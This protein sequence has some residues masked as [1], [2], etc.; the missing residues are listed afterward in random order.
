MMLLF[1][2]VLLLQC[3]KIDE[4]YSHYTIKPVVIDTNTRTILLEDYTGHTCVNCAPA[5]KTANTLQEA[6]K[7]QVFV[8]G[9]HAGSFAKPDLTHYVP[10]LTADYT[11]A[12]GNEWYSYSGFNIDQNPKGMV[13]RRPYKTKISFLPSDWNNAIDSVL[14]LP[15]AAI[16][17]LNNTY[18]SANRTV[19]IQVDTKFLL[20]F[21][22]PVNLC[23]C[24]LEDSIHGGQLNSIKPDSTPIIKNFT[25]M[26]ILRGSVNGSFG[27]EIAA[28]PAANAI[29]S[30][31]YSFDFTPKSWVP[32]HCSVIA[33]IMDAGT[34]EVLHVTK[35]PVIRP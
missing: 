21:T 25:F 7:G 24:I 4:P 28:S 30:K 12:A 6:Y 1:I 15:K 29:Y 22:S 18:N 31:T 27:E 17:V 23:V 3:T 13:N 14:K 5:A 26:H 35:S 34:R 33:F 9:V 8:I 2:S 16:M 19:S 10:Y 32:A 11:S 20:G